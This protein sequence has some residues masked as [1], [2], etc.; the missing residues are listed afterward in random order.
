M[1]YNTCYPHIYTQLKI[2]LLKFEDFEGLRD[3]SSVGKGVCLARSEFRPPQYPCKT[4][5]SCNPKVGEVETGISGV[6]W[7]VSPVES[8]SSRFVR[9]PALKSKEGQ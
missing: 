6:Y 9:D 2:K 1:S 7:P 3:D 8:M 4:T 5:H